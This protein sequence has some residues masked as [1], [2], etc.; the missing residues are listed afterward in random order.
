MPGASVSTDPELE[1]VLDEILER[2]A[3]S[4]EEQASLARERFE[5]GIWRPL[6]ALAASIVKSSAGGEPPPVQEAP[7]RLRS[8][9]DEFETAD[10]AGAA[11]RALGA[12]EEGLLASAHTLPR[13]VHIE[14]S[15]GSGIAPEGGGSGSE[16]PVHG[17]VHAILSLGALDELVSEADIPR[18][19]TEAGRSLPVVPHDLLEDSAASTQRLRELAAEGRATLEPMLAGIQRRLLHRIRAA[20]SGRRPLRALRSR[21]GEIGLAGRRERLLAE[22]EER[23]ARLS[24]AL[25]REAERRRLFVDLDRLADRMG[26]AARPL[27]EELAASGRAATILREQAEELRAAMRAEPKAFGET[28]AG[29]GGM[30]TAERLKRLEHRARQVLAVGRLRLPDPGSSGDPLRQAVQSY[31]RGMRTAGER[32]ALRYD[33]PPRDGSDADRSLVLPGREVFMELQGRLLQDV[34]ATLDDR[35]QEL[36]REGRETVEQAREIVR[37]NLAAARSELSLGEGRPNEVRE[38]VE[39][40]MVR[41]AR[42]LEA[43]AERLE[44]AFAEL[45]VRAGEL[46]H[47]VLYAFEEHIRVLGTPSALHESARVGTA[48]ALRRARRRLLRFRARVVE[49]I[50]GWFRGAFGATRQVRRRLQ[51]ELG[52]GRPATERIR[53]VAEQL[54]AVREAHEGRDLPP[55]YQWLFRSEP[56]ADV[57]LLVGRQEQ[58]H[59]IRRFREAWEEERPASLALVGGPGSG[60]SSLVNCTM[61]ELGAGVAIRRGRFDVRLRRADQLL[62]WLAR[63]LDARSPSPP[64]TADE[65]AERLGDRREIVVLEDADRLFRR[66]VGGYAAAD[67]MGEVLGATEP[68]LGW[69]LTFRRQPWLFLQALTSVRTRFQDVATLGPLSRQ[70]LERAVLL[71]HRVTGFE[72]QFLADGSLPARRQRKLEGSADPVERQRLLQGWFFDDLHEASFGTLHS[73]FLLWQHSITCEEDRVRVR[74]LEAVNFDFLDSLERELLFVLAAYLIHS[75]LTDEAVLR[76]MRDLPARVRERIDFLKQTGMLVEV[77]GLPPPRPWSVNPL[78]HGPVVAALQGHNI[79]HL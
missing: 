21:I 27:Q 61:G 45:L 41:G 44:S 78:I 3:A 64:A 73:A 31:V 12:F 50:G 25:H 42:H 26:E 1:P 43:G 58:I 30:P 59:R 17:P 15:T 22:L 48:E 8:L 23:Y 63:F 7:E 57:D 71:R 55:I 47:E 10:L 5:E 20:L 16:R 36:A 65:L 72:L 4:F 60:I 13:R 38:L 39:G 2:L 62:A 76:Q 40:G 70:D 14:V 18:I 24:R 46:P 74:P 66:E 35:V 34:P 29:D 28:D 52:A 56:L 6:D 9:A 11:H 68:R 54:A 53:S 77:Q 79:L 75:D 69:V 32:L 51:E 67:A 49:P 33:L 37:Y 19:L